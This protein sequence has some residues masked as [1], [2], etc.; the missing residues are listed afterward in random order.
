MAGSKPMYDP[1]RRM[2]HS[3][4]LLLANGQVLMIGS[5]HDSQRKRGGVRADSRTTATSGNSG[6]SCICG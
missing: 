1:I 4:A 2:Y 6:R 3:A 5:N